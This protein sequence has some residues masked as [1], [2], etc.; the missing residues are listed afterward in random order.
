MATDTIYLSDERA[1]DIIKDGHTTDGNTYVYDFASRGGTRVSDD[2]Q[3]VSGLRQ[4]YTVV[5]PEGMYKVTGGETGG[6]TYEDGDPDAFTEYLSTQ[7]TVD[8]KAAERRPIIDGGHRRHNV[9][10]RLPAGWSA[11]RRARTKAARSRPA[12]SPPAA[13]S[14]EAPPEAARTT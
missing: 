3:N 9:L 1:L 5:S 11:R 13:A 7:R 14:G 2:W 12:G 10:R 6:Y 4:G 8:T